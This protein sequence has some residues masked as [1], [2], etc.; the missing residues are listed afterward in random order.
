MSAPEDRITEIE[1]LF[2][3]GRRI[4]SEANTGGVVYNADVDR[5]VK[6]FVQMH[7]KLE[8][9][10]NETLEFEDGKTKTYC[11]RI[12][13]EIQNFTSNVS[14][15]YNYIEGSNWN[16]AHQ[17]ISQARTSM[18]EIL[19]DVR[20]VYL[21]RIFPIEEMSNRKMLLG[22]FDC[23]DAI[24][25]LESA[26]TNLVQKDFRGAIGESRQA[27]ASTVW[28]LTDKD[29]K[30]T[31]SFAGNL[32][33]LSDKGILER[34]NR[35]AMEGIYVYLSQS[36]KE[37]KEPAPGDA[38]YGI[39]QACIHIDEVLKKYQKWKSGG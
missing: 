4:V 34:P 15:A 11:T 19:E 18:Y 9:L 27:L 12:K 35:I 30:A 25:K 20:M 37:G 28:T 2:S 16:W 13:N 26:E 10:A 17:Y 7:R 36:W 8:R 31:D 3:D 14:T 24:N 32:A 38:E 22:E 1:K 33:K 23:T 29:S 39:R 5:C 21:V 6:S